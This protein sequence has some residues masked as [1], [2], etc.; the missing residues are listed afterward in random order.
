M[1]I[2]CYKRL[3]LNSFCSGLG[4]LT[5]HCSAF[6][7]YVTAFPN[8]ATFRKFI[9]EIAWETEVWIAEEPDHLIHFDGEKF[10]GPYA[11]S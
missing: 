1:S 8:R 5:R 6:I 4:T 2:I 7:V 11:K 3:L 9:A 10:L